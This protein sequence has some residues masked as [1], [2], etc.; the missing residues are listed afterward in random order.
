[1]CSLHARTLTRAAPS[2]CQDLLRLVEVDDHLGTDRDLAAERVRRHRIAG[3][4]LERI[5]LPDPA[6]VATVEQPDVVDAAVAEDRRSTGRGDLPARRPGHFSLAS[7]S[8]SRP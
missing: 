3:N 2:R 8:V 6:V 1:M 4:R 5:A 7:P